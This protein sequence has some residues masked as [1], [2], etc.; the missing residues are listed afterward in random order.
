MTS[1]PIH[2]LVFRTAT[3]KDV[4]DI[5]ELVQSA[6]RGD[7]SRNGWT[8]EADFLDGTR[9]DTQEVS[10]II[11]AADNV[12]LLAVNHGQ[13]LASVHIQKQNDAA[14]LGMFAVH[15]TMQN[16]GI[17]KA[18]LTE[19]ENM[20]RHLWQSR[21]MQMTVITIRHELIAWYERRAYLRTGINKPFPYGIAR[22]G[23]PKRDDLVL[24]V[25]EKT[26]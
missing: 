11:L 18:L 22:Y 25:L 5:V 16:A 24:E 12:I 8:T 13:L 19:A 2:P 7:S 15:P 26:L 9:T 1:S 3:L 20:A 10:D 6:Y 23:L 4:N 21:R 17:G 14:Y